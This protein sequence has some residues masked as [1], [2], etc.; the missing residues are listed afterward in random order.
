VK[1]IANLIKENK[2]TVLRLQLDNIYH[3]W[4]TAKNFL[5]LEDRIEISKGN[6]KEVLLFKDIINNFSFL[7][8]S[9]GNVR[10]FLGYAPVSFDILIRGEG[11]Q[12]FKDD[13]ISLKKHNDSLFEKK[14]LEEQNSGLEAFE[15]LAAKYRELKVKPPVSE[16]QRRYIVQ[17]NSFNQKK[18]Y[19]KA[20]ELYQKAI[21]MDQTAYPDAY[22]NLALLSAQVGKFREAIFYMKKYLLLEPESSDSRGAKDKIYEWEAE[23]VKD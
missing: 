6:E 20:I 4:G 2:V 12:K 8:D 22:S 14:I 10:V 15:P 19:N 13:L 9:Q 5:V 1:D 16:E 7:N 21:E 23:L 11:G 17:A 3:P 18:D